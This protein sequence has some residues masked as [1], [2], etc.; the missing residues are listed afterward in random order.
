MHQ[1]T[2]TTVDSSSHSWPKEWDPIGEMEN[3]PG[4]N[5]SA[6]DLEN[7]LE[8]WSKLQLED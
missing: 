2:K 3:D 4:L 7:W 6:T 5:Y 1:P 8:F